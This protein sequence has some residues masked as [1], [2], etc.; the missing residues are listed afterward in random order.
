MPA[1]APALSVDFFC[2]AELVTGAVVVVDDDDDD[3]NAPVEP[4]VDEYDD[5]NARVE[6]LVDVDA[7]LKD[8]ILD[9]L[10]VGE[11]GELNTA[12]D[13]VILK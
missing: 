8:S 7:V 6:P 3:D 11:D 1:P 10:L 12:T 4:V 13:C 2:M 9:Y 5:Y